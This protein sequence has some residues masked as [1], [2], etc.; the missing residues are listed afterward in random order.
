MI[1]D[2]CDPNPALLIAGATS[3]QPDNGTSDGNTTGDVVVFSD[4]LCIRRE[5]QGT[6][7]ADRR[8]TIQLVAPRRF[9]ERE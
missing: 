3:S 9:R 5:R 4:H 8:Y 2:V 7:R 1:K 6:D